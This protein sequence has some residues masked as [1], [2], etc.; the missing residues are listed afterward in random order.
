MDTLVQ[1]NK[2]I[3]YIEENLTNPIDYQEVVK[4]ACCSE[5]HFTRMFSFL[6]G[7]SLSEYIRRRRLTLA[8]LELSQSNIKIIDAALKYGYNSPDSF[9]RAFHSMHGVSPSEARVHGHSLKA[10]PRMSFQLTIKGGNE[11][12]YRIE[13]KESF[14]IV[15]IKK[16]VPIIFQGVNPEIASMYEGLTPEMIDEMKRFSD[17]EPSGFISA[18]TNFSEGRME[19]KGEF[20]HYIGVATTKDAWNGLDQ[21]EVA[22]SMWA[23]F[24]VVGSFPSALQEIWG[25]IYSEWAPSS[26]YELIKGPEILWNEH[27]DITSPNFKSEIWVPIT[28]K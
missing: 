14:R 23:V 9:S 22:A 21:L 20:D 7:I 10:F 15:G 25:R 5:Y 19:E 4:I 24:T 8:A 1:L 17:V 18:S 3:S 27:K 13:N 16:R 11:M 28:K 26:G 12:N 6:A 2:A